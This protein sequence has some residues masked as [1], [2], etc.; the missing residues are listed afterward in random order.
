MAHNRYIPYGYYMR[1][2]IEIH[3]EE[4]EIVKR[5]YA[6]YQIG[7]SYKTIAQ[8]L[9]DE[10]IC[11][12][13]ERHDW[14]KNR[15][16]RILEDERYTGKNEYP[17]IISDK[18][19]QSVQ[20]AISSRRSRDYMS[21][22]ETAIRSRI[23][24][25]ECGKR[26]KRFADKADHAWWKC[27]DKKCVTNF[28]FTSDMLF[29]AVANI[30]NSV[31]ENPELLNISVTDTDGFK[32]NTETIRINNEINRMLER[33]ESNREELKRLILQG[34]SVRYEACTLDTAPYTTDTLKSEYS[35]TEPSEKIQPKLIERSV[36]SIMVSHNGKIQIKFI[37]GAIVC[38]QIF[39]RKESKHK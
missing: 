25:T 1:G 23:C 16:K 37:N 7:K 20:N 11:F 14:N 21:S 35:E 4:F 10:R 2:S 17:C 12:Y 3:P 19:F 8:E 6:D 38:G 15:I 24:C 36:S 18:D 13:E 30:I 27:E 28:I 26:Y 22:E 39:P 31:I 33:P 5:I 34:V 29:S 32:P 9:T